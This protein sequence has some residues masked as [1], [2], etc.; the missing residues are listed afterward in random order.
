MFRVRMVHTDPIAVNCANAK[1]VPDVARTMV[2][3][4]VTK[5]GWEC[6]VRMCVQKDSMANIA[7]SSV[8]V[9]RRVSFVTQLADVFVVW[10]TKAMIV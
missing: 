4:I 5:V 1:M 7:L 3:A 6:I 8:R 10:A 9:R 2:I